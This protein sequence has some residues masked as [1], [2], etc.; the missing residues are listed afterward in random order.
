MIYLD[1]S[2]VINLDQLLIYIPGLVQYSRCQGAG[3]PI[4]CQS[5]LLAFVIIPAKMK[6]L[7]YL[8]AMDGLFLQCLMKGLITY[9]FAMDGILLQCLTNYLNDW[10]QFAGSLQ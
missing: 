6:G 1:A 4:C 10:D 9:L 3:S 7:A 8:F 5:V 2:K